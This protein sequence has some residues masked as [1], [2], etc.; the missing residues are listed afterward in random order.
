MSLKAARNCLL[1]SWGRPLQQPRMGHPPYT[2]I[3]PRL[4]PSSFFKFSPTK[5]ELLRLGSCLP[6]HTQHGSSQ[7]T[8]REGRYQSCDCRWR[9]VRDGLCNCIGEDRCRSRNIRSSCMSIISAHPINADSVLQSKFGEIG[10]GVGL[11]ES[12]QT[13]LDSLRHRSDW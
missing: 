13:Y 3:L 2:V 4:T 12:G 7:P 11:G 8:S 10:A 9:D 6:Q 5:D 1:R